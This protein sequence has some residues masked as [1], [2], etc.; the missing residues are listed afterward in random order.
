MK[1]RIFLVV[2]SLLASVF[3]GLG[4]ASRGVGMKVARDQG[5]TIGLSLDTLKEARWQADRKSVV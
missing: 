4:L 5:I 1:I 2:L 3:I